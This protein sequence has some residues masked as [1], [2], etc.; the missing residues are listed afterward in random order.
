[1]AIDT[2]A[3]A[4][5]DGHALLN[6]L[7]RLP[8]ADIRDL[9]QAELAAVRHT[10]D[11]S[12][13]LFAYFIMG[14]GAVLELPTHLQFCQY[15]ES[16]GRSS[17]R[18]RLMTQMPRDSLKTTLGTIAN[19]LWQL[20]REPHRPV[21]IV[22]EAEDNTKKWLRAIR[23]IIQ[24]SA[25]FQTVYRDLLPPSVH[26][27]DTRTMPRWWAWGDHEL[28]LQGRRVGEPEHSLSGYGVNSALVG[29]HWDKM[30]L[31]DL[32]G[33]RHY[34]SQ[35]EMNAVR[36]WVDAHPYLMR[37]AERGMSYVNCTP[38]TYGDIYVKM[39]QEFRYKL[40]RRHALE[41]ADGLPSLDGNPILPNRMPRDV[42]LEE[43]RSRPFQFSSQ[44]QCIP[45][46]GKDMSFQPDWV[47]YFNLEAD[48]SNLYLRIPDLS[49]D[50]DPPGRLNVNDTNRV[51]LFD[52]AASDPKRQAQ[53]AHARHG[54]VVEAIDA[55]GRRFVLE[56]VAHREDP[57]ST[58]DR[59]F[60][61]A[62]KWDVQA[63]WI[64]EVAFSNIYRFWISDLQRPGQDWQDHYLACR[65]L[66]TKGRTKDD[67]ILSL[68]PGF[69]RG[70]YWFLENT[71]RELVNEVLTYPHCD[72]RDLVDA[73]AYDR[74]L[75]RPMLDSERS[76]DDAWRR[77]T[78][79]PTRDPITGY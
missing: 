75:H 60:L 39:T 22:N 4:G 68:I 67:R 42:L 47:R 61:L 20:A 21:V 19:A 44:R 78:A 51:I 24:S 23:D 9:G 53:E 3:Q 62:R 52:P 16:W 14:S 73:L 1:M 56:A 38:W 10:L 64:E 5:L 7:S 30:I 71:T 59:V 28:D 11:G 6:D 29:H 74:Y 8:D 31:D 58:I 37:P 40:Y 63:I 65:P 76:T 45:R 49:P 26:P 50:S 2:S 12:L 13:F 46:P 15:I 77:G 27:D 72:P 34:R 54:I 57:R 33:L 36:E 69:R 35:A 70:D 55:W 66:K 32:I 43:A 18:M 48:G 79:R 17:D 25:M 41:D